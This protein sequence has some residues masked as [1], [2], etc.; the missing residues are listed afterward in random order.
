MNFKNY[1][2]LIS[3][4][5]K[6]GLAELATGYPVAP[7][8]I[9]TARHVLET[10]DRDNQKPI[11][12]KWWYH[13]P[14]V[15]GDQGWLTLAD[16][17]IVWLGEGE[18]DA[19]LLRLPEKEWTPKESLYLL[20]DRPS[21]DTRWASEGFPHAAR[22]EKLPKATSFQGNVYSKA[23]AEAYFELSEDANPDR[24][25]GWKG[26]SGMAVVV[27]N[28]ILGIVTA[29]PHGFNSAKLYA[30][31]SW[32]MLEDPAFRETIEYDD[33]RK[34]L[35]EYRA[36]LEKLIKDHTEFF[37]PVAKAL[38]ISADWGSASSDE[39]KG[40]VL[41]QGLLE[42]SIPDML[43]ELNNAWREA[44]GAPNKRNALY[45]AVKLLLPALY[46]RRIV[47]EIKIDKGLNNP[48]FFEL[49]AFHET[50]AEIIMAGVDGRAARFREREN[51]HELPK[52][53][54]RLPNAPD[55]GI[56]ISQQ[57]DDLEAHLQAKFSP[58]LLGSLQ[59]SVN[60]YLAKRFYV[61]QPG[62]RERTPD[63]KKRMVAAHLNNERDTGG[64]TFYLVFFLPDGLEEQS[65]MRELMEKIS[66]DYPIACLAMN[67]DSAL[68]LS[69]TKQFGL[70]KSMVPLK[71]KKRRKD[72]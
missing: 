42:R 5:S 29:I 54:F 8:L 33:K 2:V 56:N 49:D 31:P 51:E 21:E 40:S 14:K 46:D 58:D 59:D 55:S 52:G 9:L 10:K 3:V 48:L 41:A 63:E 35:N 69:E 38:G 47:E 50:V 19:A 7:N 15:D 13:K 67:D 45:D 30:V 71:K 66:Q 4:P 27:R 1:V 18:L 39:I 65:R 17:A 24:E 62:A 6:D 68:E 32:K 16:D 57:A 64:F 23:D 70:L 37:D 28:R 72:S 34:R 20:S 60:N 11:K 26:V 22:W 44:D 53:E 61:T 12:A 43:K 25:E 36:S